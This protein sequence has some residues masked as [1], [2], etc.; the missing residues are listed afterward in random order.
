[1]KKKFLLYSTMCAALAM[2]SCQDFLDTM[3]DNRAEVDSADKIT[4]LLVSAYPQS[5]HIVMTEMSSDN[6]MDNGSRYDVED[7]AQEE[8]YLWEDIT[9]VGNDSPQNYWD[10]C[11][12]AVAAAN[13]ALQAINDMGNP[14]SLSAQRGEALMCRAYGH[15]ALADMFCLPY[16][17]ETASTDLGLPYSMAPE[18]QVAPHYERGTMEELYKKINDDIE[19]A[20]PLISDDLYSVPKYHFNR[21]AA[22]AFAARF[23]LYKRDYE[24]VIEHADAVL[25]AGDGT[26]N[27]MLMTYDGFTE[28]TS[29]DDYANVWQDPDSKNN[30]MLIATS[31]VLARHAQP[32]LRF[33]W[34]GKPLTE[35]IWYAGPTWGWT[36][37]PTAMVAGY[38]FSGYSNAEYGFY[39]AKIG[40]QFQFTDKV[41]GV[42]YPNIIRREFTAAELLL[43]RAEAKLLG[44][45]DKTGFVADMAA[46]VKSIQTFDE[47]NQAH[48]GAN[49][50]IK[51]LTDDVIQNYFIY[52]TNP[53]CFT[54]W[55]FTQNMSSSFVIP[56]DLTPYM[57]CLNLYRRFETLFDGLRFFDLKRF[58]IEYSHKV[59]R[60]G[61]VIELKWNDPRRAL[62]LP[63]EVISAGLE[64]SWVNTNNMNQGAASEY[65]KKSEK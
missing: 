21:K 48:Y 40:E 17:P 27:G 34:S 30:L 62:E 54:N 43:E 5:T 45:H 55:N 22:Y 6:A 13:Q 16:N 14:A 57:N 3:P 41:S 12:A 47:A 11:Y 51:D 18:T 50:N 33:T 26:T 35:T 24:K 38:A 49:G 31:S 60:E 25:G 23:Y 36:I 65:M 46:Y 29:M 4:A 61:K 20:L 2:T 44:R 7:Q 39:P 64:S 32:G 52:D 28:C 58:G 10:A 59:G 19:E 53:N 9:S 56:E 63:Q 1:M 42:G 37:M 8:A 15:F